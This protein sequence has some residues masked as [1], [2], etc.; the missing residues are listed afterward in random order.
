MRSILPGAIAPVLALLVGG[1]AVAQ[2]GAE[3]ELE[4]HTVRIYCSLDTPQGS[5]GSTGSGF[6]IG[7][8]RHVITNHH[9]ASSEACTKGRRVVIYGATRDGKPRMR[10]WT[11]LATNE[12]KDIAILRTDEPLEDKQPVTRVLLS[13]DVGSRYA[14]F[15]VG[16]PG[17]SD[18]S[19]DASSFTR[20]TTTQGIVGRKVTQ[21]GTRAYQIDAAISPGSS[22][23][24]LF[25][26]CGQLIGINAAG[27]VKKVVVGYGP[28]GAPI[29]DRIPLG[30]GYAIQADE[31]VP[32]LDKARLPYTV[33][34]ACSPWSRHLDT[35]VA[36]SA[37]VA[38]SFALLRFTAF[39]RGI[40]AR[41]PLVGALLGP[42]RRRPGRPPRGP[43]LAG[44][45]GPFRDIELELD[46]D[47]VAIGRDARVSQLAL[48]P[49][50]DD[51]SKRHCVIAVDPRTGHGELEDCWSTNGTFLASGERVPPGGKVRL[52]PGTRFYLGSV[53]VMFEFR[54]GA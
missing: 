30:A 35:L 25:D 33:G 14:V 24:P 31:L 41:L 43:T 22:G 48:P 17:A 27:D 7:D 28:G 46:G 36:A 13:R 21:G 44:V 34:S 51:V 23:G 16:F 3:D 40:A 15:A 45:S 9:V 42:R 12:E 4:R 52:A 49:G 26:P 5:R 1:P 10:P 38:G 39:G 53:D 29:Y 8:G 32:M 54:A 19:N 50:H 6:L 20:P 47:P 11:Q 2:D 37:V 18:R